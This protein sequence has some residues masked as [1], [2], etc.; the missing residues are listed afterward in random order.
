MRARKQERESDIEKYGVAALERTGAEVRKVKWIG[1]NNAPDRICMHRVLTVWI[2]FK[3]PKKGAE[4]AQEREHERMSKA[5]QEV[6]VI[7]THAQVDKLVERIECLKL[8]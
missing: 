5:G 6:L 8:L 1:R 2:E 7:N 4:A 3:R